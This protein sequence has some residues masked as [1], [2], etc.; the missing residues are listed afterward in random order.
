M[1]IVYLLL[2]QY[3]WKLMCLSENFE[4]LLKFSKQ[5]HSVEKSR[6]VTYLSMQQIYEWIQNYKKQGIM[7]WCGNSSYDYSPEFDKISSIFMEI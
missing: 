5:N 6:N 7:C 4:K 2:V 3:V 1:G